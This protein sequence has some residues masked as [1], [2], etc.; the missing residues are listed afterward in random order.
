MLEENIF[1]SHIFIKIISKTSTL[2]ELNLCFNIMNV[3]LC[4][5]NQELLLFFIN[6]NIFRLF[7]D[8]L[9]HNIPQNFIFSKVLLSKTYEKDEIIERIGK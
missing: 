2:K 8:K 5:L 6:Y 7:S 4:L 1:K 3:K 9:S